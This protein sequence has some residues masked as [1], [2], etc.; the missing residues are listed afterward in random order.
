MDVNAVLEE[1]VECLVP[2]FQ[3][4]RVVLFG[5]RARGDHDEDSDIDI[6]VVM[7]EVGNHWDMA[8]AMRR[9]LRGVR[10]PK[11]VLVLSRS[12]YAVERLIPG[13]LA[14]PAEHEGTVLYART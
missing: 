12:E 9:A 11:D 8:V 5:S 3:P 7:P 1:I 4:D 13:S 10:V 2:L 14:Y 6:L